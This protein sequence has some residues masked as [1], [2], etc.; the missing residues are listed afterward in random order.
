M[1]EQLRSLSN[2]SKKNSATKIPRNISANLMLNPDVFCGQSLLYQ[3]THKKF[4]FTKPKVGDKADR[5]YSYYS[6]ERDWSRDKY[7]TTS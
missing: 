5:V 1:K 2:E 3:A 4:M 6:N 7:L